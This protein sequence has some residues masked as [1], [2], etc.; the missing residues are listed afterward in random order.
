MGQILSP[1]HNAILDARHPSPQWSWYSRQVSRRIP[2]KVPWNT[3]IPPSGLLS[4]SWTSMKFLRKTTNESKSKVSNKRPGAKRIF[5]R[6]Q[7]REFFIFRAPRM[8]CLSRQRAR[9][10]PEETRGRN[11]QG[12][13]LGVTRK[14]RHPQGIFKPQSQVSF[15]TLF[16]TPQ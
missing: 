2:W 12:T 10:E 6:I 4:W 13:Y 11:T 7:R 5:L 8:F 16:P 15:R 1:V 14:A 3:S 9:N